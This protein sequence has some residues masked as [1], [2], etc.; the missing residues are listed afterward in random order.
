MDFKTVPFE[1]K[2]ANETGSQFAG[3]ANCFNNIDAAQEI[4]APGAFKDTL[5]EFMA[6]G[7]IGGLNHNWDSPIGKPMSCKEDTKGLFVE[8]KISPT[9]HGK[10]C[11]VLLKD[12]VIQK[13]SIGYR[14]LGDMMLEDED[15]VKA[16][17]K[18]QGYTPTV[19][20]MAACQYGCRVLT[21]LH[22]FEFSPVTVPANDMAD[23][24]RVKREDKRFD[25]S[26][27]P[28]ERH[29]ERWLTAAGL[30]RTFATI[31]VSKGYKQ[32]EEVLQREA[33]EAKTPEPELSAPEIET[34][35]QPET[36]TE[37]T[38]EV[39][40]E[41]QPA[42][43]VVVIDVSKGA[44]QYEVQALYANLLDIKARYGLGAP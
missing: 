4:V 10:D 37:E 21:K 34:E 6:S 43:V 12:R 14:V 25:L 3:Y 2:S 33:D 23:I 38:A 30:T 44:H 39:K 18:D 20:D 15:A 27:F 19:A 11:M 1:L 28:T 24:T 26:D 29:F 22:L 32:Q 40:T 13:M 5:T 42:P 17:W 35:P 36:T 16:F 31:V 9:E 41:A 7:F 8:G